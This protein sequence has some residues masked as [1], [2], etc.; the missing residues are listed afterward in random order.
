MDMPA[1]VIQQPAAVKVRIHDFRDAVALQH[2]QGGQELAAGEHVD[3]PAEHGRDERPAVGVMGDLALAAV[4]DPAPAVRSD[5][6]SAQAAPMPE[7]PPVTSTGLA[8][9]FNR[10]CIS[11]SPLSSLEVCEV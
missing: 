6:A 4:A 9:E 2:L 10:L 3:V 5:R 7:A 1:A 8:G 11:Y